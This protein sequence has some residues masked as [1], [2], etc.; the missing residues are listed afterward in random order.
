MSS[1]MH[2]AG[3]NNAD[4]KHYFALL[5]GADVTLQKCERALSRT[6]LEYICCWLI[7]LW[8]AGSDDDQVRQVLTALMC[9][10][11]NS[12]VK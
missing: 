8:G 2:I 10:D 9:L 4:P 7:H 1:W 3:T 11:D 12:M 5:Q 6:W